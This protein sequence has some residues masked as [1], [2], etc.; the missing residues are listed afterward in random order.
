MLNMAVQ[1]LS[2]LNNQSPFF[3]LTPDPGNEAKSWRVKWQQRQQ[4]H[5][6]VFYHA[7][8]PHYILSCNAHPLPHHNQCHRLTRAI[9]EKPLNLGR[10]AKQEGCKTTSERNTIARH[11]SC[12]ND[13]VFLWCEW[14]HLE[15]KLVANFDPHLHYHKA[16]KTWSTSN[17][18]ACRDL[19]T[20]MDKSKLARVLKSFC[21]A[22]KRM[23]DCPLWV[24]SENARKGQQLRNER[25]ATGSHPKECLQQAD[26]GT[27]KVR[28][29]CID[30]LLHCG[31]ETLQ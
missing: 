31:S 8:R 30:L 28:Q 27:Q 16:Q 23:Q 6:T 26:G 14:Q 4:H 20:N 25:T 9:S 12:D 1:R 29:G 22:C 18:L 2:Q 24:M 7:A 13:A 19:V 21:V 15:A 11:C 5:V 3:E 17:T 10:H